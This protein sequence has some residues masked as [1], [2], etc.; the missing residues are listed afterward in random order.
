MTAGLVLWTLGRPEGHARLMWACA[1]FD[2]CSA[3]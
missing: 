2:S 3:R 1:V